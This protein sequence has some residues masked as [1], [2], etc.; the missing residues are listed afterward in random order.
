MPLTGFTGRSQA[1][2]LL[3]RT[4]YLTVWQTSD[5]LAGHWEEHWN[6]SI[7]AL[8]GLVNIDGKA[9]VFAGAP[10][11]G[12]TPPL[13]Q[14]GV[15]VTPTRSTYVFTDA[16]IE[17]TLDFLS[18]VEPNDIAKQ[19][20][21][22]GYV[23]AHAK[24]ADGSPHAVTLYFDMSGEWAHGTVTSEVDWK[25][26]T[27]GSATVL[28]ITPHAPTVIGETNEYPSWGTAFMAAVSS[29]SLS[30]RIGSDSSNRTQGVSA[31]KLD[32]SVDAKMPRAINNQW[33]VLG[34]K[35]DLGQVTAPTSPVVLV[36][37]HARDPGVRYLGT[38][39]SP[40]WKEYYASFEAMAAAALDDAAAARTRADALDQKVMTDAVA[41]GGDK[42]AALCDLTLRQAMG[43]TELVGKKDKPWMFLKEISS[44][45]DMQTVD[46][47]YP[48][49]PAYLYANPLYM[50]LLLEPL[51]DYSENHG[52]SQP[53][54]PH[55][56]G[57]YPDGFGRLD[58][59]EESMPIEESANM[60]LMTAGYLKTVPQAE[61]D[62]YAKAHY[63]ILKKWADYLIPNTLDPEYQNQTDD[64]SGFINHSANLA[65]KGIVALGA[66]SQISTHAGN[67]ADATTY[68]NKA[69][70]YIGKW[71]TLAHDKT[72]PHLLLAY[73]QPGTWSLKYNAFFDKFLGLNLIPTSVLAEEATWYLQKKNPYG[74]PLDPRH[75]Y[76]KADWELFTAASTP[77]ATL[78]ATLVDEVYAYVTTSPVRVPFSDWYETATSN[79]AGFRA[80]P[81]MGGTFALMLTAGKSLS[82]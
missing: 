18:P 16:G 6:G 10:L 42:Y 34:M 36:L 20:M 13:K 59:N 66:M 55:D 5:N 40:L 3:V 27:Q 51:F 41:V 69:M 68:K 24:S 63:G 45:G 56:I 39:I 7:K 4:P 76:T 81:V 54:A 19:S 52:W 48:A 78:K 33:P 25:K 75:T 21:P 50:K 74:I 11:V 28:S 79:V 82:Q 61:A 53:F 32:E 15:E 64:F 46:V 72:E 49:S 9:Y 57:T 31:V 67:A 23:T 70:D 80:R 65:L 77:N 44:N 12:V 14:T 58:G 47:I 73:D 71:V 2:P 17:L 38:T 29:A 26:E 62:A 22:V 37:G 43:G 35:F 8:T 30:T 1:T 60:I